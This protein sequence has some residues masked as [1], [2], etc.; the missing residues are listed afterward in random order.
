[1]S[2]ASHQPPVFVNKA[3]ITV[4]PAQAAQ[5][6]FSAIHDHRHCL[7]CYKPIPSEEFM[8]HVGRCRKCCNLQHPHERPPIV[9]KRDERT[10]SFA[11]GNEK[12]ETVD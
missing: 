2:A 7:A 3:E 4:T 12:K 8:D 1:M 11:E 10:F 9:W 6:L 5:I